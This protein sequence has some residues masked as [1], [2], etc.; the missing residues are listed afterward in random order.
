M[1]DIQEGDGD[2]GFRVKVALS[3]IPGQDGLSV[4]PAVP[5]RMTYGLVCE[6]SAFVFMSF[7]LPVQWWMK[8]CLLVG[9][10]GQPCS[11][12]EVCLAEVRQLLLHDIAEGVD[13]TE[14]EG[15]PF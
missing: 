5:K 15:L 8:L 3:V 1:A 9:Y 10:A 14:R 2:C 12:S 4:T 6:V 13:S 7:P 11:F